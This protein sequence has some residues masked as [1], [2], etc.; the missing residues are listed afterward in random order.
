MHN[1]FMLIDAPGRHMVTFGSMNLSV[2]S[3][4]ANHE[5]LVISEDPELYLAFQYRWDEVR[6]EID[7]SQVGP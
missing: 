7:S 5:L 4:H 1:K 6:Q 2:R 3:L